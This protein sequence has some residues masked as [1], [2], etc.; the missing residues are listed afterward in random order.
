MSIA[1]AVEVF[2]KYGDAFRIRHLSRHH[3]FLET[4]LGTAEKGLLDARHIGTSVSW[5]PMLSHALRA[6]FFSGGS[7][8]PKENP[9]EVA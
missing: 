3:D 7:N 1:H 9:A 8:A 5:D 4:K 6:S 2:S